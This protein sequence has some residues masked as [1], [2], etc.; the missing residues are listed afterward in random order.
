MRGPRKSLLI[1]AASGVVV[2]AVLIAV[3]VALVAV[4]G[5]GSGARA[6]PSGDLQLQLRP[7]KNDALGVDTSAGFV[8]TS[9][10]DLDASQV[11]SALKV[12]PD[13]AISVNARSSREFRVSLAKAPPPNTLERFAMVSPQTGAILASW[14]Y[15]TMAPLSVVSTLPDDQ[16]NGAPMDTGIEI[17][18]S[19]D[20]VIDPQNAIQ[21]APPTPGHFEQHGRTEVFVP[22][23]LQPSMLYTVTVK[24]GL[25]VK[26]SDQTLRT[27]TSSSSR[28][29]TCVAAAR[30]RPRCHSCATS[31][32][33]RPRTHR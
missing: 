9:G 5:G 23:A 11:S 30:R 16:T 27:P 1:A 6:L 7:N 2:V 28:R 3:V 33:S 18:F 10:V 17:T 15:Q 22:E 8:L 12:T 26:G 21:I 31:T 13:A 29:R 20:A 19:S 4:S 32:R 24:A 14:A 25:Q